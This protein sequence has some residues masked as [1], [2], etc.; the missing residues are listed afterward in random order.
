MKTLKYLVTSMVGAM[1]YAV[2]AQTTTTV[3]EQP[4]PPP[5]P[6]SQD[7][8]TIVQTEPSTVVVTNETEPMYRDQEL[9]IDAFGTLSLGEQFINSLSST[10]VDRKSV[11]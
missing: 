7:Q 11:V 5:P 9:S 2:G 6:P 3:V 1:V 10:T 8:T 4:T